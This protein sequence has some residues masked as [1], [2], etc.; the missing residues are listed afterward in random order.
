MKAYDA[1]WSM[2]KISLMPVALVLGILATIA[3]IKHTVWSWMVF[4]G[5]HVVVLGV[6]F[7]VAYIRAKR[8]N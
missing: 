3:D 6:V 8:N 7:I 1:G 2:V 4:L 5:V